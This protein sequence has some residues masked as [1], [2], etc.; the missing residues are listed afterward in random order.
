M[1]ET[2]VITDTS[3]LVNFLV[4]DRVGLLSR[5]PDWR[6]VVTDHVRAEIIEHYH[7][8][9]RRLDQALASGTL[10]EIRVTDLEE[11]RLFAELTTTGLGIGECSAIAAAAHRKLV[12][13]IDDKAAVKKA[14]RLGLGLT[15]VNTETL[16]VLLIQR[17]VLTVAEADFMK[18]DWETN[19][20]FRLAFQ[21]F[22]ERI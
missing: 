3:V 18:T 10:K 4:L 6:F 5:L 20:R 15:I 22:A 12:L 1:P 17:G 11:V 9:L 14:E 2:I 8:Q 13:A 19:H 7:D 16:I 21:S